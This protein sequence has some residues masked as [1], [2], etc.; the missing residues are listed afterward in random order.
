MQHPSDARRVFPRAPCACAVL[1]ALMPALAWAGGV[2]TLDPVEV[3]AP[4]GLV[5][6]ADSAT[7]G[8]VTQQQ[9]ATRPWLR[10]GEVLETVPGLIVT[11]HTGDG[12][13]NQF[14]LRGF[15]LD[16][17]TDFAT[18]ALGMPINL[19][20]HAH[21]QGYT[22]VNFLIPELISGIRYRKGPYSVHQGDFAAAGSAS[23][24]YVRTL[25][26]ALGEVGLGENGFRRLLAAGAP[27]VGNGTLL[28]AG[29]GFRNDGPWEVPQDYRKNNAVLRY[30]QG[31][32]REGWDVSLLAYDAKWNSTDQVAKRAVDQ[33]LIGR[34][35]TLDPTSGGN[36]ERYSLSAQWATRDERGGWR[37]N[38][39]AVRYRL[40]LFSN[41]TY[42]LDNPV[43]GDQFEQS[44]KRAILGGL[45]ERTL[46]AQLGGR[47]V[48]F[49]LGAKMR[50]DDID[51]VG[52]HLTAARQRLA[53]IR[54]DSVT[55]R[56]AAAYAEAA[57][58]ATDWLRV[59]AGVR[60]DWMSVDVSSDTAA[61]SGEAND[62]I[63]T[64]KFTAVFGP[65]SR[66]EFY[67]NYGEG[68]HSNDARGATIRVNPDP[69]DPEFGNPVDP[70]PLLVR[71]R[72]EEIGV[73]S[74]PLRGW[75]TSL[76]LWR[77][78]LDSELVFVG[79]AG[80]TEANRPS[81]RQGVEF[82]NY[83]TPLPGLAVD[84]DLSYSKARFTDSAPEGDFIPGAIERTAA[85][86]VAYDDAG[87]W[88]GGLRLR[89]FGARPLIEDDSVRSST[90]TV[91][92]A[93]LGWR[94]TKRLELIA[95]VINLF[96]R[97]FSD[98]E[99]FYESQLR[100][101]AAPVEDIHF[102]PGEPRTVRL[103]LRY[104]FD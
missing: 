17:G 38:A 68:F 14:F 48:E 42:F 64:P 33:G 50:Q 96:D 73:R 45:L 25:P 72:G 7:E 82:A 5:G 92:N 88:F 30:S 9:I 43:D 34:F 75:Q 52:L 97:E 80:T 81:R 35:G 90:S 79:D 13:A 27:R 69:R 63:V 59:V 36:T 57:V 49:T 85:L 86:G 37:A 21:G 56:A 89:Y 55:Q 102:H 77:L 60:A 83:W 28:I 91:V 61:N 11:Q 41:F 78:K 54:E 1:A 32:E 44:D 74:V 29:E 76:A 8:T 67:A 104:R 66:T 53:T 65:W 6:A 19:P 10:P 20:T 23:I 18:F 95:D 24:E 40:D 16:H 4:T 3:T 26:G 47:P 94:P 70:V 46:S 101:E 87:P 100:G 99:Y 93:R 51:T 22:D 62:S 15:N 2:Q 71:A 39:Y 58:Q 12:K 31:S 98:I 84:L 103:S